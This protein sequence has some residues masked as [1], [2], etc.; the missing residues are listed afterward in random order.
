MLNYLSVFLA[1]VFVGALIYRTYYRYKMEQLQKA[2]NIK[3]E[4]NNQARNGRWEKQRAFN[5]SFYIGIDMAEA[6]AT[7]PAMQQGLEYLLAMAEQIDGK[8][9]YQPTNGWTT[10]QFDVQ[11][12][13]YGL[14]HWKAIKGLLLDKGIVR[15]VDIIKELEL[16]KQQ[17]NAFFYIL[18]NIGVLAKEKD[19]RYNTYRFVSEDLT[20][21]L[22]KAGWPNLFADSVRLPAEERGS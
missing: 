19:G 18:A 15:G 11:S 7:L 13:L 20:P 9:V 5:K 12:F 2:I 3:I 4:S 17:A 1:G 10:L 16:D 22:L 21:D 8:E 6:A 14:L